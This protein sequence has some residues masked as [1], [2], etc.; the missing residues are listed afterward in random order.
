MDTSLPRPIAG[1]R[2]A[3]ELRPARP[4]TWLGPFAATLCGALAAGGL[5]LSGEN[6]LR[7]AIAVLLTDPILGAWR[8]AWVNTDWRRPLEGWKAPLTRAWMIVPYAQLGSP[9]AQ[10]GQWLASRARFWR[11][12]VGPRVGASI[13]ALVVTLMISLVLAPALSAAVL[14]LTLVALVLAPIESELGAPRG[15]RVVRALSEIGMTWLIGHAALS[16][17][18]PPVDVTLLALAFSMAYLG[19]L[20]VPSN[21]GR[22]FAVSNAALAVVVV[23]L[24]ARGALIPACVVGL[25][26]LAQLLWQA[27]ARRQ[28]DVGAFYLGR[29]QWLLLS[30]M[31]VSALAFSG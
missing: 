29:V 30:A 11:D 26:L 21:A 13:S 18:R 14:E 10:M 31:V 25:V 5:V 12:A 27:V 16:L 23:L 6:L 19:I 8:A 15:G 20:M 9:A 17:I 3:L 4:Y 28:T 22:G 24:F 2:I 7:I 1:R